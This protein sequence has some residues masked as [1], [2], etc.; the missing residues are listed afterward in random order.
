LRVG[1]GDDSA[2]LSL[3]AGRDLILSCDAS[4]EGV[5]FHARL[6]PPE[7]V[8]YKSLARA[9]SDLAAMGALPSYFLLT[10]AL[11]NQKTGKWLD[12]FAKGMACGAREFGMRLIGGDICWANCVMINITVLG[13]IKPGKAVLRSGARPGDFIYVSG[14]LGAAQLG[15]EVVLRGISGNLALK[16]LLRPHF[17][18]KIRLK[19]GRWLAGHQIVS[20]MMDLS[21]GLSMDLPRFCE[22]SGVGARILEQKI[23]RTKIPKFLSKQRFDPLELALHGGE[24]YQLLFTVPPGFVNRL[25]GAPGG[26]SLKLIGEITKNRQV[27][28]VAAGGTASNLPPLGWD[29]FRSDPSRASHTSR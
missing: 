9:T 29:H 13:R 7:S 5:H 10:L 3:S 17:Y 28:L 6:Q 20:A 1:I 27:L 19:L 8:G 11:P 23:P 22:A 26:T 14:E 21:D 15:L 16:R 4:L 24:D 12:R 18:P 2:V 25:R